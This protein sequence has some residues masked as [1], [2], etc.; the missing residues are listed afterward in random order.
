MQGEG[1]AEETNRSIEG[2]R[3]RK[4][5]RRAGE[6]IQEDNSRTH[7]ELVIVADTGG[8]RARV[9]Y[10]FEALGEVTDILLV[11]LFALSGLGWMD[12]RTQASARCNKARKYGLPRVC[13]RPAHRTV[14]A[15]HQNIFLNETTV[16]GNRMGSAH[17]LA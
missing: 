7:A 16:I 3:L 1:W 10:G 2:G 6:G 11:N 9:S 4:A 13:K 17:R 14:N 5:S 15:D 12:G 8:Q